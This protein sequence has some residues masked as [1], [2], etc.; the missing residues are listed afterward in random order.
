M[1][2][3]SES[4]NGSFYL[5]SSRNIISMKPFPILCFSRL[6]LIYTGHYCYSLINYKL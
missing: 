6:T 1:T 4:E 5:K 2:R 3:V